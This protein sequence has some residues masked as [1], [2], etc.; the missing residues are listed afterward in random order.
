MVPTNM[1]GRIFPIQPVPNH[2]KKQ[3]SAANHILISV[4]P[5][6]NYVILNSPVEPNA[7]NELAINAPKSGIKK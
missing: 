7:R 1:A 5:V 4:G 3:F 2:I 6:R